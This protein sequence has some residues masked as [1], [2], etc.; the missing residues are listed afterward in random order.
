MVLLLQELE[1]PAMEL[2][3][4]LGFLYILLKQEEVPLVTFMVNL[5]IFIQTEESKRP[6]Y[7]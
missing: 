7:Y 2:E 4:V 1:V 5:S 3:E 6:H